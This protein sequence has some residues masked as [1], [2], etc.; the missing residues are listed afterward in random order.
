MPRLSN[1]RW[2]MF[3]SMGL[4]L[5]LS[6]IIGLL[7][8]SALDRFLGT[9]PWLLI[10]FTISGILAGYRSVFRLLKRLQRESSE[11]TDD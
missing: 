5:G 7:L 2:L 9:E 10:V 3:S 6:V 11:Q 1:P 4:E 8:G